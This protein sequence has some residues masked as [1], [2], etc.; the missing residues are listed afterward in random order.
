MEL[1]LDSNVLFSVINPRSAAAYLFS[2]LRVDFS[3][4]DFIKSEFNEHREDCLFKSKLSE[5]EF[6]MK[7]AEVENTI[8]FFKLSEYDDFL[9]LAANALPDPDDADFVALAL[10]VKAAIWSND[11]HLKQQS[12]VK[13][14]TTKELVEA[15][16]KENL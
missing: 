13:V 12:L 15:L 14:Y 2:M 4:P 16:L 5:H 11:P 10:S 6:E 7:Q 9:E 8:K 3:A 1:V